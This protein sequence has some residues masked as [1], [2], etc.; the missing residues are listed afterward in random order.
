MLCNV[1]VRI[2]IGALQACGD[3]DDDDAENSCFQLF[4]SSC[5]K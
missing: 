4:W 2:A 3:D 1:Y 5:L